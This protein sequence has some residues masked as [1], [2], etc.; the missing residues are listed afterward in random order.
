MLA[1]IMVHV[2]ANWRIAYRAPADG[3]Y[4]T[5][6][7]VLAAY[8]Y[9]AVTRFCI[10]GFLM[11]SGAF[12]LDDARTADYKMFYTRSLH[13]LG[14]P[15]LIFAVIYVLYSAVLSYRDYGMEL[16]WIQELVTN[17]L[18]GTPYYHLW[19]MSM[20]AAIYLLAPV[21]IRFK[22]SITFSQF[23]IV[24]F[25]YLIW[26]G[27]SVNT[28]SQT[29]QW[30]LGSAAS[31]MSFLLIGYTLRKSLPKSNVKG[32]I[33][34][35][36]GMLA[37]IMT[38]WLQYHSEMVLQIKGGTLY[39]LPFYP[40]MTLASVLLFAGFTMLHIR[41]HKWISRLSGQSFLIYLIHALV[42][43]VMV[44]IWGD[45]N[46]VAMNPVYAVPIL[47]GIVC[48]ISW[49]L[50]EGWTRMRTYTK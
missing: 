28:S 37:G 35:G 24:S 10:P 36:I 14:A 30:D 8:V 9:N 40:L 39:I 38:G 43:S 41:D 50:A 13:R 47:T 16:D 21:A 22:D 5:S 18:T 25:A 6:Y 3:V 20:L 31:Y 34:I 4:D 48:I 11:L 17:I 49:V 27:I 33:C 44:L 32:V 15:A 46:V 26:A 45:E 1:V 7:Y 19:Y 23:R 2:S 29:L 42:W 12:L